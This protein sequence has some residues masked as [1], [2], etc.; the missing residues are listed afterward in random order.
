MKRTSLFWRLLPTYGVVVLLSAASITGYA[1]FAVG[2]F[3]SELVRDD[4]AIRLSLVADELGEA[5]HAVDSQRLTEQTQRL[6]ERAQARLTVVDQDGRVLSDSDGNASAMER[7]DRRPEFQE[8]LLGR[9]GHSVRSSPTVGLRMLYQAEPMLD[10]SGRVVGAIRIALPMQEVEQGIRALTR[11]TLSAAFI[12]ALLALL[13][14]IFV[15]RTIVSPIARMQTAAQRFARGELDHHVRADEYAEMQGLA[16]SL[17]AMAER[18]RKTLTDLRSSNRELQAVLSSMADGVLAVTRDE[19][20][21]LM[22]ASAGDLLGVD[23]EFA[24]GRSLQEVVRPVALQKLLLGALQSEVAAFDDQLHVFNGRDLVVQVRGTDLR[25]EDERPYGVVVLLRDVT[26]LR[27]LERM[28]SDF[29]ANVSHELKTPITAIQGFV[30]T[31]RDSGF[32]DPEEAAR[33][34]EILS[35]QSSRLSTIVDDLLTLS[36][37]EGQDVLSETLPTVRLRRVLEDVVGLCQPLAQERRI[38]LDMGALPELQV[39][40]DEAMIERALLNLV[41][42]AIKYSEPET[43][44]TVDAEASDTELTIRVRDEGCGMEQQHLTRIFE[45]FYRVDKARSRRLGGTGLGLAIVKH[46]VHAHRGRVTVESAPG[47]GSTFQV[48]LPRQG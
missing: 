3:Y 42:N 45:R 43:R 21:L 27:R 20:L 24:Q 10:E 31:L 4:V 28:R 14:C 18:L 8:A 30:E 22:N 16:E 11:E 48:H 39:K 32:D 44:V 47:K 26:E 17:N 40:M 46:I 19:T 38:T 37:F 15:S 2:R 7:H 13:L 41:D 1:I 35:R 25:G 5:F 6:G 36:R 9:S 33:F 34:L 12:I 29:V 23:A